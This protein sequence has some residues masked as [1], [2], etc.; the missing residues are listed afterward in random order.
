MVPSHNRETRSISLRAPDEFI[1]GLLS[2]V[3]ALEILRQEGDLNTFPEQPDCWYLAGISGG[4]VR[5]THED[6]CA[7]LEDGQAVA[8][9][10][11]SPLDL[12]SQGEGKLWVLCLKGSAAA[13]LLLE[14]KKRGGLFFPHG[15]PFLAQAMEELKKEEASE[16]SVSASLASG[17]AYQLLSRL[18]GT[19]VLAV[20]EEKQLPR[21]VEAALRVLQQDFAF[22]DGVG[23]LADR[24]QV[25]QEYLT[26]T[27][28][29]HVGMTPGK[30]LNQVRVEHAKL[31][32]QQGD[33]SVAF[34]A[35]AC[36]FANSNYFARVFRTMEGMTPSQYAKTVSGQA[37]LPDTMLDSFY[38]L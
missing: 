30:Y 18:Y 38:V 19:G 16:G 27:F 33:H 34:V 28:G 4:G 26:R 15:S 24:L 6:S 8:F 21:I 32:L 3:F 5:L 14:S 11:E 17:I 2:V 29:D 7:L 22:L 13:G 1:S 20:R 10:A 25:S 35:D 36:G 37:A 12:L 9:S 31:L 23:D